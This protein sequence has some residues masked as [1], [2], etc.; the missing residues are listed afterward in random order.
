MTSENS[1]SSE[2]SGHI[3]ITSLRKKTLEGDLYIRPPAIQSLLESVASFPP[4]E[5]LA[6]AAIRSRDDAGYIPSECLLYFLRAN[7]KNSTAPYFEGLYRLLS[8]RIVRS[9]PRADGRGD[10]PINL[11]NSLIRDEVVYRFI[12]LLGED[13]DDYSEGLDY[14]EVRFDGA[15]AN[16]RRDAM[17]KVYREQNRNAPIEV[18]YE[19]GELSPSV[20]QAAGSFDPFDPEKIDQDFYRRQLYSAIDTLPPEQKRVIEMILKNFPIDSNDPNVVTISK[21]LGRSEKTIRNYRDA[22]FVAL[23][24]A[25]KEDKDQ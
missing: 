2:Q 19:T 14:F 4:D 9:L 20:E 17:E 12:A 23:R 10:D 11:I 22:A 25:L 5:F 7:R 1:Q 16:L 18:D 24:A 15:L 21:S 6:R 13:C 8:E 3:S